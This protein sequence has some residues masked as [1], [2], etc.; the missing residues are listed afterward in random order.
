MD[1]VEVTQSVRQLVDDDAFKVVGVLPPFV[2]P[3][4]LLFYFRDDALHKVHYAA[5]PGVTSTGFFVPSMTLTAPTT[6]S[7][8]ELAV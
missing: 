8:P 3:S 1:T 7:I 6:V 5:L 2:Q 4:R